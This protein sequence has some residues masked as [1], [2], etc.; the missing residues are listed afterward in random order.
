MSLNTSII[1]QLQVLFVLLHLSGVVYGRDRVPFPNHSHSLSLFS[2]L[3]RPRGGSLIRVEGKH[4]L[5]YGLST[6][7]FFLTI[8]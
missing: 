8:E 5:L 1:D 2:F 3:Q 4:F 7:I 6:P